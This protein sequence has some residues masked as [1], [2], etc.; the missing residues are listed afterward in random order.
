[1]GLNLTP[2]L[3]GSS[4]TDIPPTGDARASSA[5]GPLR[6]TLL[7]TAWTAPAVI[8]ATASPA[9]AASPDC[10]VIK[11]HSSAFASLEFFNVTERGQW[12]PGSRVNIVVN[13][14]SPAFAAPPSGWSGVAF[15]SDTANAQTTV[16]SFTRRLTVD[17]R[18]NFR[19]VAGWSISEA[20]QGARWVYTF[21]YQGGSITRSVVTPVRDAPPPPAQTNTFNR[22]NFPVDVA[23][24]QFRNGQ[25]VTNGA[26]FRF[27]V[28]DV[29]DWSVA[30][31]RP[32]CDGT[33]R[34]DRSFTYTVTPTRHGL[35]RSYVEAV[36]GESME[37]DSAASGSSTNEP[38]AIESA[39]GYGVGTWEDS[40]TGD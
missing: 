36:A 3:E 20:R 12:T 34:T 32:A 24:N 10:P 37:G 38:D 30:T 6:R 7:T 19:T 29:F 15:S 11:P 21:E 28:R 35:P 8:V 40:V 5:R 2:P 13:M 22:I 18:L 27:A 31:G 23:P 39:S 25:Q 14:G 16:T 17:F 26:T 4:L 33:H 9:L 1:M